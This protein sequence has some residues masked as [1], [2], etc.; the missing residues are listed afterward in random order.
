[1]DQTG[2]G[3]HQFVRRKK[4]HQ[5]TQAKQ[6]HYMYKRNGNGFGLHGWPCC[7]I[8][9]GLEGYWSSGSGCVVVGVVMPSKKQMR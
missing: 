8:W 2:D 1:M 9:P 6:L 5:H 3:E 7:N 4:P